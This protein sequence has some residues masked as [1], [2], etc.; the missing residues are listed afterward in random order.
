MLLTRS[1]PVR[2]EDWESRS[3]HLGSAKCNCAAAEGGAGM[4]R[5]PTPPP[6]GRPCVGTEP[7]RKMSRS[8]TREPHQWY[9][10]RPS[11]QQRRDLDPFA[12]SHREN[13][14]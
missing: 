12:G 7:R 10:R 13:S 4:E 3:T 1:S 2:W 11:A 6:P 9:R 5:A 8:A 14:V